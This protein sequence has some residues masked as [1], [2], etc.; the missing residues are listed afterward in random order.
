MSTSSNVIGGI[1]RSM[2]IYRVFPMSRFFQVFEEG[3]TA[4][5]LPTKWDDPF[6][7]YVL[8]SQIRD[9]SGA[10]GDFEFKDKLY[11][12]SWTL[13]NHPEELWERYSP[14]G[15]A[16]RVQT[17]VGRLIDSLVAAHSGLA[18]CLCFIGKVTY[19]AEVELKEFKNNFHKTVLE[20]GMSSHDV[21]SAFLLKLDE[22]AFED[23]IRL[24]YFE[25]NKIKHDNGVYKVSIDP[26]TVFDEVVI[27][28]RM[29]DK[30][31]S[32]LKKEIIVKTGID[33]SR[34]KRFSL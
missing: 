10:L 3:K 31:Y 6:E 30:Q 7:N 1:S 32:K 21:A 19:L 15:N 29:L 14:N 23:E 2:P 17:T 34:I 9:I 33:K 8:V 13:F 18:S 25:S 24:I 12:Q 22:Y 16:V 26:H 20:L 11:G 28:P 4:L 5:V 27:D